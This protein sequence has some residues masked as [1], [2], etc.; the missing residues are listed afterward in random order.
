MKEWRNTIERQH[1]RDMAYGCALASQVGIAIAAPV[2]IGLVIGYWIDRSLGTL[3]WIALALTAVG[4]IIGPII[5]YRW[6][7]TAMRQRFAGRMPVED[8]KD[9][10]DKELD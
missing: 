1:V 3:P 9:T 6:V 2:L 5:A 10:E 7:T 4:A 8:A